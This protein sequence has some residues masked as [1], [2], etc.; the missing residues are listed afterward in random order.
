MIS[1]A[2]DL[3]NPPGIPTRRGDR[4]QHD[5]TID[6]IWINEATSLEDCF[7]DLDINF[8]LSLGCYDPGSSLRKRN[9]LQ[10]KDGSTSVLQNLTNDLVQMNVEDDVRWARVS[11]SKGQPL[12]AAVEAG[13]EDTGSDS[14]Q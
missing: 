3:L 4:R 7:H 2:L 9:D 1:Q 8:A 11:G 12:M 13:V 6:L 5:T 10:G 14:Y